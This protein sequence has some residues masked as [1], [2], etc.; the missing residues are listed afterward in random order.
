MKYCGGSPHC[1]RLKVSR[2]PLRRRGGADHEW[3]AQHQ[4]VTSINKVR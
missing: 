3:V 2:I 1:V 4:Q